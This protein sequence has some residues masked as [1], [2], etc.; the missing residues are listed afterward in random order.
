MDFRGKEFGRKFIIVSGFDTFRAT[1]AGDN[2]Y[3]TA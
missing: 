3:N 1:V 2:S